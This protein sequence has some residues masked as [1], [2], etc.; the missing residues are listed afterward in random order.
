MTTCYLD[1]EGRNCSYIY[2]P[3]MINDFLYITKKYIARV[4]LYPGSY[5][6]SFDGRFVLVPFLSCFTIESSRQLKRCPRKHTYQNR[7]STEDGSYYYILGCPRCRAT[8]VT[9]AA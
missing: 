1:V 8:G 6:S 3:S 5:D 4:K 2:I 7:P 9:L